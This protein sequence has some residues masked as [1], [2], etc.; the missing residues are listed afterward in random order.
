MSYKKALVL[1]GLEQDDFL[2]QIPALQLPIQ[3]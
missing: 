2:V 1:Q 3:I